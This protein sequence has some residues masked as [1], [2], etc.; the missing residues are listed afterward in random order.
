MLHACT[1]FYLG[2]WINEPTRS[3]K[4]QE[5]NKQSVAT[6]KTEFLSITFIFG[7]TAMDDEELKSITTQM[8]QVESDVKT[9]QADEDDFRMD[10]DDELVGVNK[11]QATE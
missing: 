7:M 10:D 2:L 4:K 6:T 11:E 9:T 8:D 3:T 5:Q 1:A